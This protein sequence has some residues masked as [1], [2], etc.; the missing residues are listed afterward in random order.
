MLYQHARRAVRA[1]LLV[2]V[3]AGAACTDS[4]QATLQ[5]PP[6]PAFSL[7]TTPNPASFPGDATATVEFA[8]V[9]KTWTWGSN[10]PDVTVVVDVDAHED[11]GDTS[12]NVIL[13]ES[14]IDADR[15]VEAWLHGGPGQSDVVS[16]TEQVPDGFAA[17][18]TKTSVTAQ[19][20]IQNDQGTGGG[21][22]DGRVNGRL[23]FLVEFTNWPAQGCTPGFWKNHTEL[24]LAETGVSFGALFSSIFEDAF[25]GLTLLDV[26]ELRGGGLNRLGA[27][28]VAAYLNS[29]SHEFGD[30]SGPISA[31][32]VVNMFNDV[33]PGS[34]RDYNGLK[35]IFVALNERDCQLDD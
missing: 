14:A 13:P 34:R 2:A 17:S 15:C 29:L 20:Q 27:H 28:T 18:W 1:V 32:D 5:A 30:M 26:L 21:P 31:T 35:N 22:V 16:F 8:E 6:G 7:G 10:N 11:G 25:P 3:V 33:F 4:E 9:C 23:G 12:F 24:W 19:G